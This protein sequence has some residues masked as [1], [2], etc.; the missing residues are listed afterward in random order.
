MGDAGMWVGGQCEEG[1]AARSRVR[2]TERATACGPVP[3]AGTH[4]YRLVQNL[5]QSSRHGVVPVVVAAFQGS[6][7]E[8]GL[9]HRPGACPAYL[10]PLPG[11]WHEQYGLVLVLLTQSATV[12]VSSPSCCIS[13]LVDPPV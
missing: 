1:T 2:S 7:G 13:T 10:A 3:G 4:L 6:A 12:H 8:H 9:S 11:A 5:P